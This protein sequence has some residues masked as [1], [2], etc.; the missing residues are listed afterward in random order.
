[1]AAAG[2][3]LGELLGTRGPFLLYW[4]AV[5]VAIAAGVLLFEPDIANRSP[6]AQTRLRLPMAA[7]LPLVGITFGVGIVFY[8]VLVQVGPILGLSGIPTPALIGSVSAATNLGVALGTVIFR[9]LQH[10]AGPKMLAVGLCLAAAGYCGLSFSGDLWITA[11]L[12]VLACIGGGIMLPNMLA[13]TLRT[14]PAEVR[15]RGTGAWTGAFF[16]GQFA[17]PL[18]TTGLFPVFGGLANVLLA[19][20]IAAALGMAIALLMWA[21][22]RSAGRSS[23]EDP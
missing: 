13:W 4:A 3:A 17:A 19:Y 6:G 5:P 10:L 2:G 18:L 21:A 12:A 7:V 23:I 22:A 8:T 11:A 16:M 14:L 15:G 1:L 9:R 20:G